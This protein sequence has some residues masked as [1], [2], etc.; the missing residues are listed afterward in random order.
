MLHIKCCIILNVVKAGLSGIKIHRK[1]VVRKSIW[2]VFELTKTVHN[3][4]A[5]AFFNNQ[6]WKNHSIG[7]KWFS[8]GQKRLK[9]KLYQAIMWYYTNIV[10]NLLVK[11]LWKSWE[12]FLDGKNESFHTRILCTLTA[13]AWELVPEI[14]FVR[15]IQHNLCQISQ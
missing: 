6:L 1:K 14:F 5:A 15:L 13:V 3:C 9:G 10:T 8:N 7:L 11:M 12:T 4:W 2:M